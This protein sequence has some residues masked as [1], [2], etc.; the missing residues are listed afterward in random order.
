MSFCSFFR[1]KWRPPRNPQVS[2]EGKTIIITGA[3]VG[4]GYEAVAKFVAKGAS[5]VILGV[6]NISK[7]EHAAK[8]IEKKT[9]RKATDVWQVDMGDYGSIKSFAEKRRD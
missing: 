5:K 7:G 1:V 6:R 4:L 9:G 3:N 8:E 2:F